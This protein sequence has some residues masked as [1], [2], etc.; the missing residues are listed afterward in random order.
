MEDVG[1]ENRWLNERPHNEAFA[2]RLS[3]RQLFPRFRP[4]LAQKLTF[5]G[6]EL[7]AGAVVLA[8]ELKSTRR[9]CSIASFNRA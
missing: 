5:G 3:K 6:D 1:D 2:I 4:H 8:C 9:Y 7:F